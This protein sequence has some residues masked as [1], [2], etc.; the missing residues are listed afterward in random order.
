MLRQLLN[1]SKEIHDMHKANNEL[2][3]SRQINAMIRTELAMV[4]N[5][6]PSVPAEPLA[7][8]GKP[9]TNVR[10]GFYLA[11]GPSVAAS[12][13]STRRSNAAILRTAAGSSC[14]GF[15]PREQA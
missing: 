3:R 1:V 10:A 15:P 8:V 11:V 5:A 12:S 9:G 2:R 13:A 6:L 4:A 14:Q 7:T